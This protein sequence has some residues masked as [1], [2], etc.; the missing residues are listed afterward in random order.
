MFL[1]QFDFFFVW[2]FEIQLKSIK[3]SVSGNISDHLNL[4]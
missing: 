3:L 2:L 4:S 1:K